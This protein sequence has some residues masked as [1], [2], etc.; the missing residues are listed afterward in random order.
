MKPNEVVTNQRITIKQ[1][2]KFYGEE[3]GDYNLNPR[4][5]ALIEFWKSGIFS[6]HVNMYQVK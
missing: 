2:N 1:K 6:F 4:K 3:I 5:C